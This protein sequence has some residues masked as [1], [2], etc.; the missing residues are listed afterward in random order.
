MNE[1]TKS[2]K[3]SVTLFCVNK[4]LEKKFDTDFHIADLRLDDDEDLF[5]ELRKLCLILK[6]YDT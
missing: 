6:L 4:C 2:D 5:H 3:L 1:V